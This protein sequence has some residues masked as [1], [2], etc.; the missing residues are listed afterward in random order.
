MFTVLA[1]ALNTGNIE[2]SANDSGE[3]VLKDQG[4]AN[5]V[6]VSR[7]LVLRE[8]SLI[9]GKGDTKWE[10]CVA[11]EVLPLQKGGRKSFSHAEGKA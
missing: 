5:T 8:W 3:A 10:G 7:V 11:S 2:F 9:T 1:G 6:A 4:I